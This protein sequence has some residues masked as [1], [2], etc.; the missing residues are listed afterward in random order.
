MKETIDGRLSDVFS[1][2]MFSVVP[3][4]EGKK[5]CV[6]KKIKRV[7]IMFYRA[8]VKGGAS[9]IPYPQGTSHSRV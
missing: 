8:V 1:F 9:D 2:V 5:R 3:F 7:R 4:K 6:Y